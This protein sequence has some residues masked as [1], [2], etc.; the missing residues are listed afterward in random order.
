MCRPGQVQRFQAGLNTL[1]E[2]PAARRQSRRLLAT[3]KKNTLTPSTN[4]YTNAFFYDYYG[5]ETFVSPNSRL[6]S[7]KQEE[8]T[9]MTQT[10]RNF[11]A[12]TEEVAS[13]PE[14]RFST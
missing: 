11:V 7:N 12:G 4:C 3:T 2:A 9:T 10:C 14:A 8:E 6:E 1:A 5:S 13:C